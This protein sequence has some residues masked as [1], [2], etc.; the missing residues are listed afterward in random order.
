LSQLSFDERST[1]IAH[2]LAH[3]AR[4]DHWARWLEMAA[5]AVYWWHPVAWW[6]RRKVSDAG[7][8]CCDA[9]VLERLPRLAHAYAR[10]LLAAVEFS[11]A[12]PAV[13]P[14]GSSGFS[15]V[16][17]LKRRMEM[18]LSQQATRRVGWPLRLALLALAITALPLT[19]RAVAAAQPAAA[20]STGATSVET[21]LDR[22]EK[23]V[24]KLTAEIRGLRADESASATPIVVKTVPENGAT[25]VDPN[26][27]EIKVTFSKDMLDGSWSWTQH[28]DESFPEVTGKI[29]YLDD[30]RTCVLPV[31]LEP[32][33]SYYLSINSERFRNFKDTSRRPAIPYPIEFKTKK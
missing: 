16:R 10:T 3:V 23:A 21:R 26:L 33:K 20:K 31:K 22:L 28:S 18:I 1:L 5:L 24:E 6:A 9:A 27:T 19:L 8:Q 7:E 15:Q 11:T 13:L 17:I 29:H 4:R 25:D 2:E 32:G 12:A 30:H 14:M